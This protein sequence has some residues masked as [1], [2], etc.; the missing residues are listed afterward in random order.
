MQH[1]LRY[2]I[3]MQYLCNIYA[4]I[5][6][7]YAMMSYLYL[8]HKKCYICKELHILHPLL[9]RGRG[10]TPGGKVVVRHIL[11]IYNKYAKS[12]HESI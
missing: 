9:P 8:Q 7:V 6:T 3:F 1:M 2:A 4:N 10:I 5:W 12:E 11:H